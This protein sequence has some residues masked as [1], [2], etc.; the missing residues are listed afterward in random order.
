[1]LMNIRKTV[2]DLLCRAENE[3]RF[4]NLSLSYAFPPNASSEDKSLLVALFYGAVEKRITLD[5]YISALSGRSGD[6]IDG[7]TK[8][9]LRMG[10]YQLIYM[11]KIPAFAAVNESV[12]L[13]RNKGEAS[14]INGVLR[15][16]ER[17]KQELSPPPREKNLPRHLSIK[18]S[19]PLNVVK[20]FISELGESETEELLTE[21]C[22]IPPLSLRV[23]T[24]KSTRDELLEAF[25]SQGINA[26][27]NP[28]A[29]HGIL[30]LDKVSPTSLYGFSSGLF[31]VQ[32]TA[33]QIQGEAL[34][35][36][37]GDLIID[38]CAC[39]GG[40]SFGA[41]MKIENEGKI[42][43]LDIHNS[44]LGLVEEGAKRLSVGCIE[45]REHDSRI[46]IKE[47]IGKADCVI[48]DV[49]CSGLGVLAKK[50]DL[51]YREFNFDELCELSSQILE[52][53]SLY[54]KDG[55]ELLFST[56]TLNKRENEDAIHAFLS[57]H[58]EF[59]LSGFSVG[60]LS[61]DGTLTLLPHKHKCD[62]FFIAKMKKTAK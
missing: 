5:Y 27:K 18:Y 42:L 13:A 56:C 33:S 15:G 46:A 47:Y 29:P 57:R 19:F 11:E 48:C 61:S 44:K 3:N 37:R 7:V 22:K 12:K 4:V 6:K 54:V 26:E 25:K 62:G 36:K 24:L 16:Y 41:A 20:H 9:I 30:V 40:K 45:S 1:M 2:L 55:G 53:S 52:S 50:P 8:N 60:E 32:D 14:F 43:S 34:G 31:F 21:F 49:P 23:N 10:L 59:R 51:R 39:P 28:L 58:D 17:K 35:A 38:V